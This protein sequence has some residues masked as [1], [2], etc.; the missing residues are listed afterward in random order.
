MTTENNTL[1]LPEENPQEPTEAATKEEA[2][3]TEVE[4]E[5]V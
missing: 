1:D 3:E 2:P 5:S 4:K